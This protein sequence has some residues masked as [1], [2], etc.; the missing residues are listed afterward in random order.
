MVTDPPFCMII[1]IGIVVVK[2]N[3]KI[4]IKKMG[5]NIAF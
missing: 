4:V 1:N 5:L 2:N 3:T